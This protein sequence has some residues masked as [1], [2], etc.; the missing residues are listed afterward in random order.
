M[1]IEHGIPAVNLYD[2]VYPNINRLED[3]SVRFKYYELKNQEDVVR[4]ILSQGKG[5]EA[6]EHYVEL[7]HELL[8]RHQ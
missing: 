5:L 2:L 6:F 8:R 7:V 1:A 4:D 3:A